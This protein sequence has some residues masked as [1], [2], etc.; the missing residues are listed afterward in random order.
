M[1][2]NSHQ[3]WEKR[4]L[5][6]CLAA[7][8]LILAWML[9]PLLTGIGTSALLA[10]LT[11][12]IYI[13]LQK[14]L[15]FNWIASLTTM[16]LLTVIVLLPVTVLVFFSYRELID[17]LQKAPQN[18][19]EVDQVIDNFYVHIH[20]F[21]SKLG[22]K[23]NDTSSIKS[24]L[25][26]ILKLLPSIGS[27]ILD[28]GAEFSK[29]ILSTLL[30]MGTATFCLFYFYLDGPKMIDRFIHLFP[31]NDD[32]ERQILKVFL[33]VTKAALLGSLV[34]GGVQ[35]TLGGILVWC[36]G[37]SSP[38][39]WGLVLTLLSLLPGIG[40]GLALIPTSIWLLF[41]GHPISALILI[42]GAMVIGI[43]DNLLRPLLIGRQVH[44]HELLV[45][46]F[47]VGGIATMGL[48]GFILGPALGSMGITLLQ[49]YDKQYIHKNNVFS[50]L[51]IEK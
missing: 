26:M 20:P 33:T 15:R 9:R 31:M 44:M 35:G 46:L 34:I 17:L 27:A 42:C 47:T 8:L 38:F 21:L 2:P 39:A 22:I 13:K 43:I 28:K 19:N 1:E 29:W 16:I 51:L 10:A 12:P 14:V 18:F 40:I 11:Y 7:C 25:D 32:D 41:S 23:L 5:L 45:F 49:L 4:A 3:I 50:S 30:T 48:A 6:V 37:F 24:Q 36:L